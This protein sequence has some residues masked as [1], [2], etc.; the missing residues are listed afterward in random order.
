MT[1]TNWVVFGQNVSTK[2]VIAVKKDGRRD[3]RILE[4]NE[5]NKVTHDFG[6]LMFCDIGT[7]RKFR[8]F[9]DDVIEDW[10]SE[11]D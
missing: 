10:E 4:V 1:K 5:D 6:T 11:G 9:I 3:V 2:T 8:K 7:L